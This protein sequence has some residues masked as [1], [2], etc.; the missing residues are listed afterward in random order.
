MK[1]DL[2][3]INFSKNDIKRGLNLPTKIN[4]E[5]AED[6]GVMV[7]DGYIGKTIRPK[8]GTEYQVHCYGNAITDKLFYK[9]YVKNLKQNLFNLDFRF[10]DKKKNTCVL[11]ANS[12]GLLEFYTSIIGLPLGRKDDIKVPRL[13]LGA[14]NKIK[15]S[16]IKGLADSDFTFTF[17]KKNK[18]KPYYP[19][20]KLGVA[21]KNLIH[22][23]E[24]LLSNFKFKYTVSYDLKYIHP[25][26]KKIFLTHEISLNGKENLARWMN[27]I[28]FNNPKNLLKYSIWKKH[29]FCVRDKEI[30]R[31]MSGLEGI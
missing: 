25:I 3:K 28:G 14:N 9:F 6:I 16:F 13:I 10:S 23:I 17:R 30:R 20:I 26:T 22:D 31:I 4:R 15:S 27:I 18:E 21:S 29:G 11:E 8:R 7:G 24:K 1:F 19:L 12:R 5:L 2:S